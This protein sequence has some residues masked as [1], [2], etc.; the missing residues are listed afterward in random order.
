MIRII[1]FKDSVSAEH[2][3]DQCGGYVFIPTRNFSEGFEVGYRGQGPTELAYTIIR[4]GNFIGFLND[5]IS[6]IQLEVGQSY[7]ISDEVLNKYRGGE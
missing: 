3:V 6:K 2:V 5:V 4:N 7:E 1:R